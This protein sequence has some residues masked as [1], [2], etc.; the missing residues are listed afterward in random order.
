MGKESIAGALSELDNF[1]SYPTTIFIDR[2]GKIRKIHTG[3]NGPA[4]G[5]YYQEFIEDFNIQVD[6][7]LSAENRRLI[8]D[9]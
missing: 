7:L 4:T 5:L 1:S 6:S 3:F 2:Q 9:C 8:T